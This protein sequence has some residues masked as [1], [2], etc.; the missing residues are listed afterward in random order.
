M[1]LLFVLVLVV[2]C[3][4]AGLCV[5]VRMPRVCVCCFLVSVVSLSHPGVHIRVCFVV[6]VGHRLMWGCSFLCSWCVLCVLNVVFFLLGNSPAFEFYV[7]TFQNTPLHLH[8]WCK[9]EE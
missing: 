2:H 6:C 7:P 3:G 5:F 1:Y 4:S 9:Q 8:R